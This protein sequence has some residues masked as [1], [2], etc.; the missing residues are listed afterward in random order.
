MLLEINRQQNATN[1]ITADWLLLTTG[2]E[3][4]ATYAL[5]K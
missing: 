4:M 3:A 1:R 5:H 2:R